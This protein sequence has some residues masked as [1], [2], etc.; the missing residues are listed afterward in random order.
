MDQIARYTK[1]HE[2][3]RMED[4]TVTPS[5]WNYHTIVMELEF[6]SMAEMEEFWVEFVADLDTPEL[7]ARW[8]A[9]TQPGGCNEVWQLE[10]CG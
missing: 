1:T 10:G 4:G 7:M 6:E 3:V 2:W 9:A 5:S 8:D